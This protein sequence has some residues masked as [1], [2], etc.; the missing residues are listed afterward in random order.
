METGTECDEIGSFG[1]FK[2]AII[3]IFIL[4]MDHMIT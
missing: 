3:N 1:L 2:A 4:T